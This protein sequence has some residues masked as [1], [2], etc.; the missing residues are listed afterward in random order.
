MKKKLA[1]MSINPLANVAS[2]ASAQS[3]SNAS[4]VDPVDS[5]MVEESETFVTEVSKP[6]RLSPVIASRMLIH[7]S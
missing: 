6:L 7:I 5:K 4:P 2:T 3:S 1:Q